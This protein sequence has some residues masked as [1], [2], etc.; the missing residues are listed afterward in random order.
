MGA[1]RTHLAGADGDAGGHGVTAALGDE[2]LLY[3]GD[4]GG[5]EIDAGHGAAGAGAGA[6]RT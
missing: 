5:T 6:I 2:P 3:R 4:D 1:E